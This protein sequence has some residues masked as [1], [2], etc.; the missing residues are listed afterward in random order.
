M[1]TRTLLLVTAVLLGSVIG[2]AAAQGP[3][4]DA[5]QGG[6]HGQAHGR[7]A[8]DLGAQL[9]AV[10][11]ATAKYH[12][13]DVA[14]ADGYVEGSPCVASS[15][16][17]MGHHYVKGSLIGGETIEATQPQVLLYI[18]EGDGDL[19]LVGVEYVHPAGGEVLGQPLFHDSPAG[20][21]T[22][23]HVWVWQANP[24]G[25]FAAYNPNLSC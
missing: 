17:A 14:I 19:R 4:A 8:P 5:P 9:A 12:D 7:T 10:R 25:M 16:G 21:D 20:P 22:A 24:D 13:V 2:P 15:A 1:R 23:L 11:R 18:P 6:H 3:P